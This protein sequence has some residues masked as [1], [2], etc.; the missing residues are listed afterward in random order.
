MEYELVHYGVKGM[1]WG[2]RKDATKAYIKAG[3]KQR[4]LD[5][6]VKYHKKKLSDAE[7]EVDVAKSRVSENTRKV[8]EARLKKETANYAYEDAK[9]R[10]GYG[11]NDIFGFKEDNLNK[12]TLKLNKAN[13]EY[14]K[15]K[16]ALN[17]SLLDQHAKE[18][19]VRNLSARTRAVINKSEKWR[20][21]VDTAFKD[22]SP[23][24]IKAGDEYLRSKGWK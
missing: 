18:D 2:I 12:A 19:T 8:E 20:K 14:E 6:N 4:A 10:Y 9:R 1:K 5:N 7:Y 17:Q 16:N 15:Q 3:K 24:V 22:V 13:A 21:A 11:D 23:D